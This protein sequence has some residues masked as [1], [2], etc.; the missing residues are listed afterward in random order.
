MHSEEQG[1][2]EIVDALRP[3][4]VRVLPWPSWA[5]SRRRAG[6]RPVQAGPLLGRGEARGAHLGRRPAL[7][8]SLPPVAARSRAVQYVK[9]ARRKGTG[10]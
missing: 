6:G 1:V 5:R 7:P 10:N 9:Q 4:R 3:A 8:G 2:A